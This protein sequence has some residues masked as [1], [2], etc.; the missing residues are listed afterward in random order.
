MAKKNVSILDFGSEKLTIMSGFR[1][2]NNTISVLAK[3]E[4]NYEGFSEG[5]FL[6]PKKL[7]VKIVDAIKK[8]EANNGIKIKELTVGVPTEFCYATCKN[9]SK[10][11]PKLKKINKADIE[12]L[13]NSL[14]DTDIKT[15]QLINK[16]YVYFVLGENNKVNNPIGQV[17]SKIT[18]CLSFIYVEKGF[19]NLVNKALNKI[20][21]YKIN[22]VSSA[23][24]QSLYLFDDEQRDNYA[25][26]V[27]CGYITT[28]VSL[29]RGRGILNLSSFS[30]GGGH[31]SADLSVCLKIPFQSAETLNR[32]IVLSVE[33]SNKDMYD[34]LVDGEVIPI[35]MRVANAI[36]E[37]RIEV[38][39]NGIQKCF[40][41]WKFD[42][43]NFISIY[44]TGGG[45]SFIRGAKDYI[46]KVLGKNIELA[47]NPYSI[48]N[49]PN[50]SSSMAVLNYSLEQS[51]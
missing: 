14:L 48:Y 12:N 24:A 51:C 30:L 38:I 36:V 43:P 37:S 3:M 44:L 9:V 32:K 15:H 40:N 25:L 42:F 35:S 2:V 17:S 41:S 11:F 6:E 45:V 39:A 28:S 50:N 13:Y 21:I 19:I 16:G 46:S 31:I 8:Y 23:Y 10:T 34:L 18:A 29:I 26:L 27:D 49:K 1:D 5:E 47:V 22:Y 33:P 4:E 20:G 7:E